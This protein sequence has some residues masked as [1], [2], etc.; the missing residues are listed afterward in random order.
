MR[1]S[2]FAQQ[3]VGGRV[4]IERLIE[5]PIPVEQATQRETRRDTISDRTVPVCQNLTRCLTRRF[6]VGSHAKRRQIVHRTRHAGIKG[7]RS[8][9]GIGSRLEVPPNCFAIGQQQPERRIRCGCQRLAANMH[10]A[11]DIPVVQQH[12]CDPIPHL[13]LTRRRRV[14]LPEQR[15]RFVELLRR[16]QR[17][18]VR[19]QQRR[20]VGPKLQRRLPCMRRRQMVPP[21]GQSDGKTRPGF[22]RVRLDLKRALQ[23]AGRVPSLPLQAQRV[24]KLHQRRRRF[25]T[26]DSA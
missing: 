12:R 26:S 2:G 1:V 25:A 18:R 24:A 9:I 4:G 19:Q 14:E 6:V 22:Q 20:I 11:G 5:I 15:Q 23:H 8:S 13:W 10:R 21:L 7:D 17:A 16:Y 3:P